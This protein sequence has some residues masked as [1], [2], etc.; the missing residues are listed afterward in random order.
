MAKITFII[1]AHENAGHIVDF[2]RLLTEWND[3]AR[4]IIHYDLNSPDAQFQKLKAEFA[5]SDRV[6]LINDRIRCGWGDF[7]LVE[8][9]LRGLRLIRDKEIDCDRVMLVSGACMPI[10]P[11]S[12][13]SAFL[14]AHPDT[15]YIETFDSDWIVGGLRQERYEYH[16]VVN[17]RR[18][19]NTFRNLLGLQKSLKL[20]RKMPSGMVPKFGSQWWTLTWPLC[21][22]ILGFLDR[23]PDI[24]RFF[25]TTWIPDE[26]FFQTLTYHLVPSENMAGHNLTFYQFNDWGLPLVFSD[27]HLP[28]LETIPRFFAR[29]IGPGANDLKKQLGEIARA[30]HDPAAPL[31][32][33]PPR[34]RFPARELAA[35]N[36]KLKT[37]YSRLFANNGTQTLS[38]SLLENNR[39][40]VV[41]YGPPEVAAQTI[42]RIK[43]LSGYTVLGRIFHPQKVDFGSGVWDFKGLKPSDSLVR[44]EYPVTYLRRIF[45][46]CE[47]IPVFTMSPGDN[48]EVELNFF[49][50]RQ[51]AIFS[52]IPRAS[53][54]MWQDLYWLLCAD[55]IPEN[56]FDDTAFL[57]A[58]LTRPD[59]LI[60]TDSNIKEVL[61]D[62]LLAQ[63]KPIAQAN[64]ETYLTYEHGASAKA[65]M[66]IYQIIASAAMSVDFQRSTSVLPQGWRDRFSLL[67]N[68]QPIWKIVP[69][70]K[71]KHAEV[72]SVG[73]LA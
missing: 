37:G 57:H 38:E 12:E 22:K 72:V 2:A 73:E 30:P 45:Q 41:L 48:P 43:H 14:D 66:H 17:H 31:P 44:D 63:S 65:I 62:A 55:R 32:Q 70:M 7:S 68:G 21:A 20:R 54:Q 69:D 13:L 4:A 28:M 15:E 24:Y 64:L 49:Q 8:A 3:E 67:E 35:R 6:H 9:V 60:A 42:E 40:F 58:Y 5:Q 46:R 27:W 56:P 10:R 11:L 52:L 71:L 33:L 39:S 51:T 18:S 61:N 47:G 25:R 1:L 50:S 59:S 53:G 29:K 36:A 26:L 19:P 34:W 16:H 23:N